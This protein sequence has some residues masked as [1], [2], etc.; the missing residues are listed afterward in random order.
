MLSP[1]FKITSDFR[2]LHNWSNT[3]T[4][5][6]PTQVA[7]SILERGFFRKYYLVKLLFEWDAASIESATTI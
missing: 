1:N 2:P 7:A 3:G 5:F 6:P 4:V